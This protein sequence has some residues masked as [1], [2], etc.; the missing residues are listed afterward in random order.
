MAAGGLAGLAGCNGGEEP[1]TDCSELPQEP[2]YGDWF[3][4][5][6]NYEA[7]CDL[8]DSDSVE[9]EVGA[10]GN[11]AFWAFNPAAI[12][13]TTGTTV[14]WNWTGRGGP[15]N[16]VSQTGVLDSGGAVVDEGT[17]FEYRFESPGLH[18]YICEPHE[19]L[20]MKGAVFIALE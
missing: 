17:E 11:D 10:K 3:D 12:A 20:G 4:N 15:H 9:I 16:V 1:N 7:T 2:N 5:V 19:S 6:S 8:R 18:R 14:R 13:I